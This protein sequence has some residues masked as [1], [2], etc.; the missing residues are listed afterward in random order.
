M[1]AEN[2]LA[3]NVFFTLTDNSPG[4]V[5]KMLEACQKY[6]KGHP[7]EVFFAVGTLATELNRPVNDRQFDVALHIV[8][9]DQAAHDRYQED[10]RHVMFIE[11][12]RGNWKKVRV[13]DSVAG[14]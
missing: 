12:N 8:F 1:A 7:G 3:H 9:V 13:F 10:P 14:N 11:E 2:M 6:L 4:E 5:R